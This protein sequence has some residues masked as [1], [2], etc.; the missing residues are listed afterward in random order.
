MA[1]TRRQ[2]L[3]GGTAA[4][5]GLTIG[6]YL[7]WIPGTGVSYAAGPTDAI[8]VFVQL[9]GGNDGLNTLYPLD[10]SQR[11]LY[12][13][14][15][16]TLQLPDTVGGLA[17]WQSLGLAGSA[18]LDVGVNTN[19]TRYALH[20]AMTGFHDLHLAGNLAICPGVHYP[21]ANHSHFRSEEI[22]Y[23]LDPLGTAGKGWFGQY[24]DLAA[25]APTDVPGVMIGS[26]Q[27]PLF[28]P[29]I[30]SLFAF[31]RLSELVFPATDEATLKRD[32]V[33]EIYQQ[34]AATNPTLFPERVKI[35]NT[36]QATVQKMEEYYVEGSGLASAGKVEALLLDG[37]GNYSRG[38]PLVYT[39]PLNPAD[40]PAVTDLRLARDLRHVAAVIRA[41]VGARFFHVDLGGFDT[42][43]SQEKG[44]FHSYLLYEISTAVA[45]FFAE[46]SQ[47]VSLPGG[48]SGYRSGNLAP[49]VLIV[50]VSEFG[51][52]M[53]QN[54][55]GANSAGT[56][57]AAAAPQFII[58]GAVNGGQYGAYP[59]LDDPAT[60]HD[61][62]LRMTFDF[63]DVYGTIARRWLNVAATDL[64]PG[65]G[66]LLAATTTPD[67]DGNT[68]T[69]FT[70][71]G[72][73]DP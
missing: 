17:P 57:H 13:E 30:A 48:Y 14:Y 55:Q 43:S 39:S 53:R 70:P 46:I 24:M 60:G 41:D 32:I 18:V 73:L 7:R 19:G 31:R 2:F 20:P 36:G 9:N 12:E 52:T 8:V 45:A 33:L 54:A 61:D 22:Y 35:G 5:A 26:Q 34:A 51:R 69:A 3:Q 27:H 71:I 44:F 50:T 65:P 29:T 63:R 56:D 67:D 66:K 58:G 6:P 64:G 25:F 10:T 40:N 62:D 23:T 4:A 21:H 28:T 16:P 37:S 59:A 47:S 38:N 11:N 42:H 15:R 72:F 49:E 1:I 68:Y